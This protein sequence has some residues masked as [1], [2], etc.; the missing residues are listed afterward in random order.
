[1]AIMKHTLINQLLVKGATARLEEVNKERL[2]L[3]GLIQKYS[4]VKELSFTDFAKVKTT[5]KRR[6]SD[7]IH[8]MKRPENK[9]RV[10][11]QLDRMRKAKSAKSK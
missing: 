7:K 3:I 11:A 9:A 8:W 4:S 6:K 10:K 5:T 1:M 2:Q